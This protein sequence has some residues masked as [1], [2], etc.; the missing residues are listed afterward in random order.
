MLGRWR[1]NTMIGQEKHMPT[2]AVNRVLDFAIANEEKASDFYRYLAEQARHEHMKEVFLGFAREEE[3]HKARLL[4]V[5]AGEQ[6]LAPE[7]KVLD[8]GLAEQ[9]DDEP[10]DLSGDMDYAQALII[11]MKAEKAAYKLY[12]TLAEATN[13]PVWKSLLLGLAQ[14]EAKHKLR[15]EIEYD[16][17]VLKEQ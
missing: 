12:H 8:L 16:D 15:F 10:I 7:Q 4:D 9:L 17:H 6:Q 11:A 1:L 3:Q 5:K 14:E 13:N 2:D